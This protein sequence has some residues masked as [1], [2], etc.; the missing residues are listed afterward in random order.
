ML[1]EIVSRF[2]L[3]RSDLTC[4]SNCDANGSAPEFLITTVRTDII[5]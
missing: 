4:L 1:P 2:Q 5:F 3:E